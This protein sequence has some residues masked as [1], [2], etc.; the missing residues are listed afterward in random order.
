MPILTTIEKSNHDLAYSWGNHAL[1]GYL[2][3]IVA[4]SN[5]MIDVTDPINPIISSMPSIT[6]GFLTRLF[7]TGDEIT[8]NAVDYYVA[9]NN[10]EGTVSSANQSVTVGDG[11]KDYYAQDF[12]TGAVTEDTLYYTGTYSGFI[13]VSANL[14]TTEAR[15]QIE[16][17]K[18]DING[19]VI[20]SGISS[21]PVG[22]LGV[23]TLSVMDSGI[24]SLSEG[25]ITTVP[26]TAVLD[27]NYI[28][29]TDQRLRFHISAE[30]VS[31][32]GGNRTLYVYFGNAKSTFIDIP[33]SS[34]TDTILNKSTVD[35]TYLSDALNNLLNEVEVSINNQ[36]NT[37]YTAQLSDANNVITF[38]NVGAITF[39][40]PANTSVA[41][42]VGTELELIQMSTGQ[43]SITSTDSILYNST[44]KASLKG[45]Y[46][47]ATL[48]KISSTSWLLSGDLALV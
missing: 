32:T 34:N 27:E 31:T 23:K 16:V 28:I 25:V 15:F 2:E 38:T 24:I 3:S 47:K 44:Y 11:V 29:A 7:A 9:S 6:A 33:V 40:V 26:I 21:Q 13:T 48:R 35:G 8:V 1:A 14:D 10:D 12:I 22:D 46:S 36:N 37:T 43:V 39:T 4:G 20:D 5:T 17:Y 18:T 45:Q 19:N 30:K 41:F 42:P